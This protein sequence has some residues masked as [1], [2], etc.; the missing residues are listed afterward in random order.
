MAGRDP[1]RPQLEFPALVA[2][3][4]TQLRLT[5]QVG[6]LNFSDEVIPAFLIGSRGI[7]FGGG[8]PSF[9]SPGVFN[10]ANLNPAALT[11]VTDTGPLPAGTYDIQGSISFVGAFA[12]LPSVTLSIQHRDAANAV[13]LATLL[14]L[15]AHNTAVFMETELPLIGYELGTNERIRIITSNAVMVGSVA[16]TVFVQIRP[17]P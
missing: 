5:G 9:R 15:P 16:G 7:D 6:R 3:L 4:I 2:E 13:T 10:G 14:L 11:V 17:T 8:G 12:I 1:T